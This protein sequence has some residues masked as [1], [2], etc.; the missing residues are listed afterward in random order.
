MCCRDARA[1]TS[2]H[3]PA[4]RRTSREYL[5]T[6]KRR[7]PGHSRVN[8][9]D[10]RQE[11]QGPPIP[12]D[13]RSN[14][15][16]YGS[17]TWLPY[18]R[19]EPRYE[20]LSLSHAD[21]AFGPPPRRAPVSPSIDS[22]IRFLPLACRFEVA[23][24]QPGQQGRTIHPVVHI[25]QYSLARETMLAVLNRLVVCRPL[26]VYRWVRLT[27]PST[28]RRPRRSRKR[29][30]PAQDVPDRLTSTRSG[31]EVSPGGFLQASRCSRAWSAT[32]LLQPSGFQ[33]ELFQACRARDQTSMPPYSR[34]PT[35]VG[36]VR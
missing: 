7:S 14:T 35:V 25:A 6:G 21:R 12:I 4:I 8:L 22:Q 31:S 16:S 33:I 29:S 15:K 5:L 36:L 34:R 28:R 30:A 3:M 2:A 1:S 24:R 18:S 23:S 27:C 9:V 10:H 26:G 17:Q 19:S 32:S 20:E 11:L 13:C